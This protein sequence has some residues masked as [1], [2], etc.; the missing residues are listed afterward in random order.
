MSSKLRVGAYFLVLLS[1]GLLSAEPARPLLAQ[2]FAALGQR[3]YGL[4]A[5]AFERAAADGA[6]FDASLGLAAA[7][8]KDDRPAAAAAAAREA[9]KIAGNDRQRAAA[10]N[11]LG[12]ALSAER[13][14]ALL[15]PAAEAL[16]RAI[17]LDARAA[18]PARIA[19]AKVN[20]EAGRPA[21]AIASLREALT[22]LPARSRV[23]G[24]A[25]ILLCGIRGRHPETADDNLMVAARSLG[26]IEAPR[27]IFAPSPAA[28]AAVKAADLEGG[29]VAEAVI[30]RDGCVGELTRVSGFSP[31][32]D[33]EVLAGFKT[34]VFEPARW[35][36]EAVATVEKLHAGFTGSRS[37]FHSFTFSR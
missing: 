8:L 22:S 23:A 11:L 20:E 19:L 36:G 18:A 30:D 25:R 31:A 4:A 5:A 1:P 24:E 32:I 29:V 33:A 14:P 15:A 26:K 37:D 12:L 17:R 6:S 21:L 3:D 2:G 13:D 27:A 16:E 28:P 10:A 9:E 7:A 35:N 34:W